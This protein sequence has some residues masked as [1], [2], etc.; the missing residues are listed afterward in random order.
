MALIITKNDEGL[1]NIKISISDETIHDN[2]WVSENDAKKSLNR[3]RISKFF[4]KSN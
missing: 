3:K 4:R 2:E 1:Y